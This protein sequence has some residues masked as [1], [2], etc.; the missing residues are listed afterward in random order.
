MSARTGRGP[1]RSDSGRP[2]LGRRPLRP[3]DRIACPHGCGA[4]LV[5]LWD[6][7]W[8][9]PSEVPDTVLMLCPSCSKAIDLKR[10]SPASYTATAPQT[11]TMETALGAKE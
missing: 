1:L 7:D 3:G 2:G 8:S 6:Y 5:D 10:D 4:H 9:H 11:D